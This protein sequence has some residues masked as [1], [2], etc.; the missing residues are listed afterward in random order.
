MKRTLPYLLLFSAALFISC[1]QP[2][3]GFDPRIREL[4][5]K[6]QRAYDE[7][8]YAESV[9]CC[10]KMLDLEPEFYPAYNILGKVYAG[11]DGSEEKAILYFEKSLAI[12]P[13]QTE[14][15][16]GIAALFN[17][18]NRPD[19]AISC[20]LR[21]TEHDPDNFELNFNAGVTYLVGKRDAHKALEFLSRA[22]KK[23]PGYDK[24]IY[25]IGLSNFITGNNAMAL[26]AVTKLRRQK[27][28]YLASYLE[29]FM[30]QNS[31]G[32]S[33]DMTSAVK[34][35]AV[36]PNAA[37]GGEKAKP[38]A[39]KVKNEAAIPDGAPKAPAAQSKANVSVGKPS[40]KMS[41]SG[42]VYL[43]TTVSPNVETEKPS[44]EAVGLS[45]VQ[46]PVSSK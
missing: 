15:Y 43:K 23:K 5:E 28:E 22:D 37:A 33:V 44:G 46:E 4:L 2:L 27:N 41:G 38:A 16:N 6:A 12:K 26:D 24:L 35:Y 17:K 9:V 34:S 18:L 14:I 42:T 39:G 21:G 11:Q 8:I 7:A 32:Q 31:K 40:T 20:F 25:L 13:S 1:V 19:D 30:R 29:S 3:Y 10:Q 36:P 45:P